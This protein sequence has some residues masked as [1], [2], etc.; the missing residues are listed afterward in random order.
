[1]IIIR[2]RCWRLA[3]SCRHAPYTFVPA[4][5]S[6]SPLPTVCAVRYPPPLSLCSNTFLSSSQASPSPCLLP[7]LVQPTQVSIIFLHSTV[8]APREKTPIS[9]PFPKIFCRSHVRPSPPY[10]PPRRHS[11]RRR[12]GCPLGRRFRPAVRS[13]YPALPA[14]YDLKRQRLRVSRATPSAT[15]GATRTSPA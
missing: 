1:M 8:S 12:R 13:K 11:C 14:L 3:L 6:I 5:L 4:V 9:P 15:R 7:S 2:S 10:P